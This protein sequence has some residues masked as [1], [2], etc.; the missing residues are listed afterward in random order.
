[1]AKKLTDF[2]TYSLGVG[3]VA[4]GV[5]AVAAPDNISKVLG[6]G[7]HE[8]AWGRFSLRAVGMRDFAFG[9]GILTARRHSRQEAARW[10]AIF[11]L[12]LLVDAYSCLAD[13][14]KPG[15][16]LWTSLT[17]WGLPVVAAVAYAGSRRMK[18]P[19]L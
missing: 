16:N 15:A 2:V 18:Q 8:T 19:L 5:T 4:L 1:M 11:S 13:R 17:A 3:G 6:F 12:C 9:L 7:L 14:R 10:Q